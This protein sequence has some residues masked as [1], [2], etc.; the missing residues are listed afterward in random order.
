MITFVAFLSIFI[1]MKNKDFY[2]SKTVRIGL[3]QTASSDNPDQ[4]MAV[5][6]QQIR[7]AAKSGAQIVCLQE[8]FRTLYFCNT[9]DH[10]HFRLAEPVP[11][12]A[13]ER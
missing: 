3:I 13:T 10:S 2:E 11:G 8:L 9:V 6:E 5:A 1:K 7:Q 12:P 4:N